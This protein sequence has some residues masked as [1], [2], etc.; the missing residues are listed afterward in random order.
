MLMSQTRQLKHFCYGTINSDSQ[1]A[2]V[3]NHICTTIVDD[4]APPN[5]QLPTTRFDGYLSL[6]TIIPLTQ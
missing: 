2:E 4:A 6:P 1:H 3:I 5:V